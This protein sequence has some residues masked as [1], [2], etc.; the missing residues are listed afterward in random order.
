MA[1]TLPEPTDEELKDFDSVDKVAIWAGLPQRASDGGG[2]DSPRGTLYAALGATGNMHPRSIAAIPVPTFE[3]ALGG[4]KVSGR[5]PLPLVHASAGLLGHACR[6]AAGVVK[7]A[8]VA[9][10]EVVKSNEDKLRIRELELQ[11]QIAAAAAT[12]A[13]SSATTAAAASKRIRLSTVVDQSNDDEVSHMTTSEVSACYASYQNWYGSLPPPDEDITKEQLAGLKALYSSGS[14]PYVDMAV[15]G[16]YGRRIQKKLQFEGMVQQSDGKFAVAKLFGPPSLAAWLEGWAVFRTGSV[17]LG[18]LTPSTCDVWAKV[19]THYSKTYGQVMWALIYQADVRGRLE[20]LE[21]V[22][23]TGVAASELAT[24]AG[25]THP[26]DPQKPWEWTFRAAAEDEKFWKHELELKA[27]KIIT[28]MSSIGEHLGGDADITKV[29]AKFNNND[30]AAAGSDD[31]YKATKK[32][33]KQNTLPQ[34]RSHN[35]DDNGD[36]TH[37]RKGIPLC[38]AF[39]EN[40]CVTAGIDNKCP[41]DKSKVHQ[42]AKCLGQGHGKKVCPNVRAQAPA[43]ARGKGSKGSKGKG[44]R[45]PG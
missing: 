16:P 43:K 9:E 36:L 20:H 11:A 10:A 7:R 22:R 24:K 33:G 21:R 29:V 37:N 25:G 27:L 44:K 45:W 14:T 18:E 2:D 40:T 28:R 42:C 15:W 23:R 41:N 31:S 6:L 32:P 5:T 4:W 35:V 30:N 26:Y 34:N 19:M 13:A 38:G 1:L 17:M 12:S 3:M 8:T 39:Q